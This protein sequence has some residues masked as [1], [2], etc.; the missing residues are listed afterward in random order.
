MYENNH[1]VKT[2]VG[3]TLELGLALRG[4]WSR[5]DTKMR[6]MKKAAVKKPRGNEIQYIYLYAKRLL[7]FKSPLTISQSKLN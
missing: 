6:K 5:R 2:S 1:I 3:R 7:D 4:Q